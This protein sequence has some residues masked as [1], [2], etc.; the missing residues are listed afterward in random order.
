MQADVAEGDKQ[1]TR[2]RQTSA[3]SATSDVAAEAA[4]E[5]AAAAAASKAL[6]VVKDILTKAAM[7]FNHTGDYR[8]ALQQRTVREPA[9]RSAS[10][11]GGRGRGAR[12]GGRGGGRPSGGASAGVTVRLELSLSLW[13]LN[14]A[15]AFEEL[16]RRAR[17]IILTS[18]LL[19]Y[20]T[21]QRSVTLSY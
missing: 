3:R 13:C 8:M 7:L 17:S 6:L 4:A 14:P 15:V 21:D 2:P 20:H 19:L 5:A 11:W 18:G 12:R 16:S 10:T 9:P 1:G